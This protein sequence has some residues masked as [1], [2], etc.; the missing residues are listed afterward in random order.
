MWSLVKY[1]FIF[2]LI[3]YYVNNSYT[4]KFQWP[5]E[6]PLPARPCQRH[7]RIHSTNCTPVFQDVQL[8]SLHAASEKPSLR[9]SFAKQDQQHVLQRK[10]LYPGIW[11]V[12]HCKNE[13][14]K[15]DTSSSKYEKF[16]FIFYKMNIRNRPPTNRSK[17]SAY[18]R[19]SCLR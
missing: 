18:C 9:G 10:N 14:E 1:V 11:K 16:D 3:D 6:K 15:L 5:E 19:T 17:L 2:L 12:F 4:I 8:Q 7:V 13:A